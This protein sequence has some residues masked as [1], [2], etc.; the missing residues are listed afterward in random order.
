MWTAD[1]R[2]IVYRGSRLG[3]RNLF[4]IAADGSGTE[5]RL[6]VSEGLQ[7]PTS[8][9]SDHNHIAF[10]ETAPVS[11]PDVWVLSLDAQEVAAPS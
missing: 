10:V 1:G 6:A 2:R 7:T 3:F 11:G 8:W 9:S 5:E 4:W